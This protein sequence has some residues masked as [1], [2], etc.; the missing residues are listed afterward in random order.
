MLLIAS[1]SSFISGNGIIQNITLARSA[2]SHSAT[3]SFNWKFIRFTKFHNI[4]SHIGGNCNSCTTPSLSFIF[5]TSINQLWVESF[6]ETIARPMLLVE[7]MG[8]YL[9]FK[10]TLNTVYGILTV[11]LVRSK[12]FN[13]G[14]WLATS[15]G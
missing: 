4:H 1:S 13:G 5:I 3:S 7:N 14:F 15:S 11:F 8:L 12:F 2:H 10:G 9:L 6:I